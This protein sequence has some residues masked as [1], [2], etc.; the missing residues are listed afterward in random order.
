MKRILFML[1]LMIVILS[2]CGITHKIDLPDDVVEITISQYAHPESA[3]VYK[4]TQ[5]IKRIIDYIEGLSLTRNKMGVGVGSIGWYI[6]IK[7]SDGDTEEY[8]INVDDWNRETF[9]KGQTWYSIP[10]GQCGEWV[11]ILQELHYLAVA[12]YVENEAIELWGVQYHFYM[13][14]EPLINPDY[15]QLSLPPDFNVGDIVGYET[16]NSHYWYYAKVEPLSGW[17]IRYMRLNGEDQLA[18]GELFKAEDIT[19]IPQWIEEARKAIMENTGGYPGIEEEYTII[20]EKT[21]A[22]Y[23]EPPALSVSCGN[24]SIPAIRTTYSWSYPNGNGTSSGVEADGPHPLEMMEYMTP[25]TVDDSGVVELQFELEP[26]EIIIHCWPEIYANKMENEDTF[27]AY[28]DQPQ[29][30]QVENG[31][32]IVPTDANYIYEVCV[33]WRGDRDC[34]GN[35]Y[36]GF[37]T[38]CAEENEAEP[39]PPSTMPM[40]VSRHPETIKAYLATFPNNYPELTDRQDVIVQDV[41]GSISVSGQEL[42]AHF[43]KTV[44]A[45]EEAAVTI[46]QFTVEGDAILKYLHFDGADFYVLEDTTRDVFGSGEYYEQ[47]FTT[48]DEVGRM[49]DILE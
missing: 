14:A 48:L 10:K 12:E 17:L 25:L 19:E 47:R 28:L 49:L 5:S 24:N 1:S 7:S 15:Y 21:L 32:V 36:F 4:D 33:K 3:T 9:R 13:T 42:W 26:D 18:G 23:H 16:D 27:Y 44:Q 2:S 37:W 45:D 41:D 11:K 38:V 40:P 22:D 30:L 29:I 6:S 34:G 39:K 35:A 31:H 8:M 43:E 46:I 20:E